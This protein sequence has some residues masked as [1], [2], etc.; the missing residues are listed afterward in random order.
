MRVC[1]ESR[2]G[3]ALRPGPARRHNED[4]AM[5]LP[6]AVVVLDGAGTPPEVRT[7]CTHGAAWYV[8]S[9]GAL[10]AAGLS[11]GE[12]PLAEV[13]AESISDL[14]AAHGRDCDTTHPGSPSATVA[15]L[16]RRGGTVDY[17]VLCDAIV[18]LDLDGAV[19]AVSDDR[20][21]RI[22]VAPGHTPETAPES[23]RQAQRL[24]NTPSGFWVAST[25]PEA[26]HQA[27]AGSVTAHR[28]RRAALLSDGAG[29][30][31][32]LFHAADWAHTMDLLEA[33]GPRALL[34]VV[35]R[36]E[37]ADPDCVR[38]PRLKRHDDATAVWCL[39]GGE[40]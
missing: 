36:H 7:G 21:H 23:I 26:A 38:W 14:A 33:G 11:K 25:D 16:R 28:L 3:S 24:R 34:D 27:L 5:A 40:D 8:R 18:L 30:L 10:L 12:A 35:R 1:L 15:M 2:A 19:E 13:L 29:R 17:L 6:E 22:P 37:S 9:L 4:W 20:C 31:V 32:T 39:P